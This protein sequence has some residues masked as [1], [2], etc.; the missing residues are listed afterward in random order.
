MKQKK[1]VDTGIICILII[2]GII[3][4]IIKE[5]FIS[6]GIMLALMIIILS[7]IH[8]TKIKSKVFEIENYRPKQ[9]R[10]DNEHA[11]CFWWISRIFA[12]PYLYIIYIA[13]H[14]QSYGIFVGVVFLTAVFFIYLFMTSIAF[15]N[16]DTDNYPSFGDVHTDTTRG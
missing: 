10:E 5:V 3:F 1:L 2:L 11:V 13:F 15:W 9:I 6:V 4:L 8:L 14:G 7:S 12:I 16:T